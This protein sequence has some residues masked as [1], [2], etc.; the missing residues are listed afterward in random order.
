MRRKKEKR[1]ENG[2]KIK[3]IVRIDE[4]K[5]S[6][7]GKCVSFCPLGAIQIVDGKAFIN[8]TLCDG[9]AGCVGVC[10]EGAIYV[11]GEELFKRETTKSSS[12]R[13]AKSVSVCCTPLV[14]EKDAEGSVSF[15]SNFPVQLKIV[16]MTAEFLEGAKLL[17]CADC[18]PF[19]FADFHRK[20]LR[21]KKLVIGCPKLDDAQFYSEKLTR[22][23]Q[24]NH[25]KEVEVLYME[26]PC[27]SA[28]VNIVEK[29]IKGSGREIPIKL[30]KVGIQ[31]DMIERKSL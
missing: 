30:T 3:R 21:G 1:V 12:R 6:G 14:D 15:L 17:V 27:C 22:I 31:G 25:I 28:L 18:V 16:P 26:V 10:P 9:L 8:Q 20:F 29:A 13:V 19:A 5:C 7:C 11:E 4:E 24:K 23:F 2:K